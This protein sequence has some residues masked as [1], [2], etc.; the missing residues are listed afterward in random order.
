MKVLVAGG[1]GA[2]GRR[3]V[4]AL[5]R[6][7]HEVS[8]IGRSEDELRRVTVDGGTGYACD[9]FDAASVEDIVRLASPDVVIDELTSLPAALKPRQLKAVYE[10]NNRIRWEGGGNVLAAAKKAG[11]RRIVVQSAAYWYDPSGGRVKSERE[12]L[13][14][15]APEPIGE[16][17]RTM[18]RVEQRA[19]ESGLEAVILRY[20]MFYGPGTWYS[21]D[22]DVGR[23]VAARKFPLIGDGEGVFSFIHIDD[24]ADATVK[25]VSGPVGVYNVVDDVPVTFSQWLPAFADALGARPPMRV[26]VWL[27]RMAAGSAMVTWM[28]TL[29]GASN[30]RARAA[31]GWAPSFA[32]YRE[33]FARGL[34]ADA[35]AGATAR[36]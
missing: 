18:V 8:V 23:Q 32:S 25:A 30:A 12:P 29:K 31:L 36:R 9:V 6:D 16:A 4:P 27:A 21:A 3:L 34:G 15:D 19:L 10:R 14:R 22:G 1:T 20:G 13:F 24:A 17:V 26:P 33:G 35:R 7:G 28:Q 2:I 5:L 11:V